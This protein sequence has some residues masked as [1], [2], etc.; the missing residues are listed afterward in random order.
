MCFLREEVL[1]HKRAFIR[2]VN[3]CGF[4]K[5]SNPISSEQSDSDMEVQSAVEKFKV[6]PCAYFTYHLI[7][8]PSIFTN[9]LSPLP[10][11]YQCIIFRMDGCTLPPG[12][13]KE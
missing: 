5:R 3:I 4:G 6:N 2:R 7:F 8:S 12:V 10:D 9:L 13:C 11:Q 1:G